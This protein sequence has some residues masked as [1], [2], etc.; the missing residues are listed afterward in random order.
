MPTPFTARQRNAFVPPLH[1][2]VSPG[3]R[4]SADATL[5]SAPCPCFVIC[6]NGE[7]LMN[8]HIL[9]TLWPA[10]VARPWHTVKGKPLR[11]G[12]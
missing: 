7:K 6:A 3:K 2:G 12:C 8:R 11:G 1:K 5:D 4:L 10:I 9:L